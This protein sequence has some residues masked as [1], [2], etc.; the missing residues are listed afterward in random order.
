MKIDFA[1]KGTINNELCCK[2]E[3]TDNKKIKEDIKKLYSNKILES[4]K[5]EKM[6]I[7]FYAETLPDDKRTIKITIEALTET[8]FDMGWY[9][10]DNDIED[11]NIE[12]IIVAEDQKTQD[13]YKIACKKIGL[14]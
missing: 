12:V 5:N 4:M 14:I 1:V 9:F 6:K 10:K 13:L 2:I 3:V 8:L 7:Y 11:N